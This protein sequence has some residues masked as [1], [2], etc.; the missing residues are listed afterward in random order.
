MRF[1]YTLSLSGKFRTP[2]G[3]DVALAAELDASATAPLLRDAA[4]SAVMCDSF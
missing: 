2:P 4:F 1:L 3:E